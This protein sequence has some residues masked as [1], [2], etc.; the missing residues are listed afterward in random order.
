MQDRLVENRGAGVHQEMAALRCP[1]N[2]ARV[3]SIDALNHQ[4]RVLT[5]KRAGTEEIT[6]AA[7]YFMTLTNQELSQQRPPSLRHQA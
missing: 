2:T 5:K 7:Q 4:G 6:I 3:S 1:H